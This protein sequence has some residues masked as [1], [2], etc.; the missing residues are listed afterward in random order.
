MDVLSEFVDKFRRY[1]FIRRGLDEEINYW[2]EDVP[3]MLLFS[4]IGR[5]IAENFDSIPP[6]ERIDILSLIEYGVSS[7]DLI[8]PDYVATGLLEALDGAVRR[9]GGGRRS[10]IFVLLGEQS[11]HYLLEWDKLWGVSDN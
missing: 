10:K 6:A 5:E 1:E 7:G 4:R 2:G 9:I 3:V 11:R 8:L